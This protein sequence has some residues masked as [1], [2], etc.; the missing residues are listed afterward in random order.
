MLI[1]TILL[2]LI[3]PTVE[4]K[5]DLSKYVN[6]FKF[7]GQTSVNKHKSIKQSVNATWGMYYCGMCLLSYS[8]CSWYGQED[9]PWNDY[10]EPAWNDHLASYFSLMY[11]YEISKNILQSK[12]S[13]V[14][15]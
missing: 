6:N 11:C 10:D 3:C 14:K 15:S 4:H 1:T 2:S 9:V 7:R 13:S 8:Y 5:Y 12:L